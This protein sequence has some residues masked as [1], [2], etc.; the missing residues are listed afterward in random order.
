MKT[1][2]L[3]EDVLIGVGITVSLIDIQ[4]VLS[5]IL[6]VFN[7]LWILWKFGYKVYT[8]IKQKDYA[9][10][11]DDI[12]DVKDELEHLTNKDSKGEQ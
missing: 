1:Q 3:I 11:G 12:E 7:V 8:H 4:Q 6:L 9:Q 10:I 5:I 2:S